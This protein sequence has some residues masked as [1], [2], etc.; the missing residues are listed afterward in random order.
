MRQATQL[1]RTRGPMAATRFIQGLLRDRAP[2]ARRAPAR[3]LSMVDTDAIVEVHRSRCCRHRLLEP[4]TRAPA[5]T[6]DTVTQ[7]ARAS[8][9]SNVFQVMRERAITSC[10]FLPAI[11]T[12]ALPLV[13][14]LHGCTQNPDDFATGTR[15]NRWA[16]EQALPG[17]LSG[18]D[19]TRQLAPVLELVS[20]ARSAGGA[21]RA[22]DHRR[23]RAA[24]H[25]RISSR[26]AA[27]L[28]CRPVG[29]RR[30]GSHHGARISGAVCRSRRALGLAGRRCARCDVRIRT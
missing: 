4:D 10:T 18:T 20:S 6:L 12:A 25:R 9:S 13:V 27:R 3:T 19:S 30:D 11:T 16:E 23:H 15:A 26:C 14:M 29:R 2:R 8:S 24:G 5:A 21:R 7:R 17:R 1:V 28:R 22:G